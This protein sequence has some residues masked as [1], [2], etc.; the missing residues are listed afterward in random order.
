[1]HSFPEGAWYFG[2]FLNP[3]MPSA[4]EQP[5]PKQEEKDNRQSDSEGIIE[6][7]GNPFGACGFVVN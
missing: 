5:A 3:Q 4:V 2:K 1:M 6:G 7:D